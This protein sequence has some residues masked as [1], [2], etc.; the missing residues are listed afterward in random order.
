MHDALDDAARGL[1]KAF[2]DA[3]AVINRSLSLI[4]G[5]SKR[6]ESAKPVFLSVHSANP[7]WRQSWTRVAYNSGGAPMSNT[8]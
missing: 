1:Q 3:A 7:E 2:I 4:V 8:P 6:N 5:P